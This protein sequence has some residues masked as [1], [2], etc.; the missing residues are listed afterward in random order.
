MLEVSERST[1]DVMILDLAGRVAAGAAA[2]EVGDA[3]RRLLVRGYR[4]VLLNLER[5]TSSDASGISAFLGALLDARAVGADVRLFNVARKTTSLWEIMALQRYFSVFDTE[6]DALD[7][8]RA[9]GAL[10]LAA[11]GSADRLAPAA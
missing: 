6:H 5:T 7:S 4:K 9:Q 11:T 2:L 1:G 10:P 3:V 8:F